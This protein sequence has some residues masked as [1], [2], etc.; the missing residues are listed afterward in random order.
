MSDL[1]W[2]VRRRPS[3]GSDLADGTHHADHSPVFDP[4]MQHGRNHKTTLDDDA[5]RAYA[6]TLLMKLDYITP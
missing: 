6:G 2:L 1:N 4:S 5:W 3:G